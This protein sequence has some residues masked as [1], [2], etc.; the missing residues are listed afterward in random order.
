MQVVLD[1]L[2]VW[3]CTL[4]A[5]PPQETPWQS[6]LIRGPFTRSPVTASGSFSQLIKGGELVLH[7]NALQAA[8]ITALKEQLAVISRSK[9]RNGSGSSNVALWSMVRQQPGWLQ[10]PLWWL[11]S[12]RGLVVVVIKKEPNQ[13][14]SVEETVDG[15]N[16]T[17]KRAKAYRGIS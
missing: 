1:R 16:I 12:Q 14:Y 8:R 11:G 3:L 7:Q 9:T 5:P 15:R 4:P 2:E 13:L 17:R 6:K 10:R